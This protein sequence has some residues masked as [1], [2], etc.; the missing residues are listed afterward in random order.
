M[1]Q[2]G[3]W[4]RGA[5]G[6]DTLAK[7]IDSPSLRLTLTCQA[8]FIKKMDPRVGWACFALK[9]GLGSTSLLLL[10]LTCHAIIAKIRSEG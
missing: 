2:R 4:A 3:E 7:K 6:L 1:G 10:T 9:K 5:G 8:I